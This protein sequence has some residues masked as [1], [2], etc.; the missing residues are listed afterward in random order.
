MEDTKMWSLPDIIRMNA[1]AVEEKSKFEQ[2]LETG[3]LDGEKL[4]CEWTGHNEPCEGELRHYLWYDIFSDDP[5]G[6]LT[7]CEHHDGYYGSPSEGYFE[8]DSCQRVF[9]DH[10]TWERYC[11]EDEDGIYC[12][13]CYAKWYLQR[14][15]NW[16][17]LTDED[18]D[19][20]DF[21]AVRGA[22]HLIGVKMPVPKGIKFVN[23]VEFDSGT[24]HCIS[25]GEVE[26]LKDT[27]R[28]QRDAGK[29]RAILILDAAYQF[30]VSIGVYVDE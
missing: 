22:R 28:A 4:E 29:K 8:C 14:E 26:E 16:I 13:P 2:A 17:P 7:L 24:G 1:A 3:I 23:N 18:I 11:I 30:A 12:L 15:E 25:G 6:I 21:D 19:A 27:L 9:V 10:Y 20:V 5:K